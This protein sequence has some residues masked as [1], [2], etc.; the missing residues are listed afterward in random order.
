MRFIIFALLFVS[1]IAQADVVLN[2]GVGKNALK[3]DGSPFERAVSLGYQFNLPKSIFL[4]PQVGYFAAH[5]NGQLSSAWGALLLGVEAHT[6]LGADL[7]FAVGPG[8]LQ[9]PDSVL[10]GR[11]QFN[12][13]FGFGLSNKDVALKLLYGHLSSGPIYPVN[14]GR[15]FIMAQAQ[16]K[17]L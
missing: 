11:I 10:G 5:G 9:N 2:V 13:E 7:S 14:Q 4:R 1:S 17:F 16:F 6:E 15:D 12:T 8:Y 3:Q